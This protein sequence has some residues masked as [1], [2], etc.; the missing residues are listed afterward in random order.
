MPTAADL[1]MVPLSPGPLPS[2][3]WK[4]AKD[5][6]QKAVNA[7]K[8]DASVAHECAAM[9]EILGAFNK[10]FRKVLVAC[11]GAKKQGDRAKA[12]IKAMNIAGF[13]LNILR[14]RKPVL[15]DGKKKKNVPFD[16]L[17]PALWGLINA[18]N[19]IIEEMKRLNVQAPDVL[20]AQDVGGSDPSLHTFSKLWIAARK[21]A[22][23]QKKKF[24]KEYTSDKDKADGGLV[25]TV[26]SAFDK[27][28]LLDLLKKHEKAKNRDDR[29]KIGQAALNMTTHHLATLDRLHGRID[30]ALYLKTAKPMEIVLKKLETELTKRLR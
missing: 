23:T 21:A 24:L 1:G 19:K 15:V 4:S 5:A 30:G 9:T 7:K 25:G 6:A 10:G 29:R 17:K 12:A 28:K 20:P 18:A 16:A 3:V 11:E 14:S 13:Y 27:K 26:T 2:A 8:R 22:D